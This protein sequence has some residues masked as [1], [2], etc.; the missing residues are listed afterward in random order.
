MAER[1]KPEVNTARER[2]AGSCHGKNSAVL[3]GLTLAV[4]IC[5]MLS[6][7]GL[8]QFIVPADPSGTSNAASET[9]KATGSGTDPNDPADPTAEVFPVSPVPGSP[10]D[11]LDPATYPENEELEALTAEIVKKYGGS[12]ED[13][14]NFINN[15]VRGGGYGL[16]YDYGDKLTELPGYDELAL[17]MLKK[18]HGVCYHYAALTYYLLRAAGYNACIIY[19]YRTCDD[20]LHYWT[21]VETESGWYHF[22]PL[23][24][25]MLLTDAE[26]S[27]DD[28]TRGNGLAW[29]QGVWPATPEN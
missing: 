7:C 29:K 21:M 11:P 4:F 17:Y 19:G 27:S 28:A 14:Y 5:G 23:H 20:A 8:M 15:K 3:A 2:R 24:H 9:A 1:R 6:G 12:L 22:D 16:S 25:Q 13:I 26:K 18:G 10:E